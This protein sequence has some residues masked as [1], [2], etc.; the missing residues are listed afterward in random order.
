MA[1]DQLSGICVTTFLADWIK[2]KKKRKYSFRIVFIP[3]TIGSIVYL[4]KKINYMK[5]IL[6]GFNIA[7][8]GMKKIILICQADG[9][10]LTI[11]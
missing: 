3:E 11:K 5:K 4:R 1:N 10:T 7:C 2:R 8:W 9:D 6:V